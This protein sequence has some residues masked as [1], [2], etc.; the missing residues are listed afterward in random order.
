MF[1]S[2][3][4]ILE[5]NKTLRHA[6]S[7]ESELTLHSRRVSLLTTAANVDVLTTQKALDMGIF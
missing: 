7:L 3:P 6:N 2:F 1:D 4:I 5:T